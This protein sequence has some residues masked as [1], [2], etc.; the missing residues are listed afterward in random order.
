MPEPPEEALPAPAAVLP[1]V[2]VSPKPVEVDEPE[3]EAPVSHK[4]EDTG[5]YQLPDAKGYTSLV[6]YLLN[7]SDADRQQTRD[8]IL[9]TTAQ[10]FRALADVLDAVKEQGRVVVMG[11]QGALESANTSRDGWL[12]LQKVM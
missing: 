5:A 12:R 4:V 7:E 3:P 2:V 8:Q 6:R 9:S 11:S 10:D 1:P